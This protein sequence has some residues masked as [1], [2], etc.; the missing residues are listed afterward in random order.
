MRSSGS[1]VPRTWSSSFTLGCVGVRVTEILL[2]L[3]PPK[4][5]GTGVER[6]SSFSCCEYEGGRPEGIEDLKLA[7]S[8][9]RFMVVCGFPKN[10]LCNGR[11]IVYQQRL[12]GACLEPSQLGRFDRGLVIVMRKANLSLRPPQ[13]KLATTKLKLPESCNTE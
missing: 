2:L 5:E 8:E 7:T 13:S 11:L 10:C 1:F 6:S 9:G 3:R 12:T 4:S